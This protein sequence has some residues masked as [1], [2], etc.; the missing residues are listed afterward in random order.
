M[1]EVIS[2]A[3]K[4]HEGQVRKITKVPY[5]NHPMNVANILITLKENDDM[6]KAAYLHD[7]IED[8]NTTYEELKK[9]FGKIVA[10]LVR[11]LTSD[12]LK[13]KELGKAAYLA[14][15]MNTM[16]NDA[17]TVKLAD[18]LDNVIDLSEEDLRFSN[19][20]A[21]Q[22]H[23]IIKKI[24]RKLNDNQE[25]LIEMIKEKIKLFMK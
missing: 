5:I 8:T 22:T 7:T 20:Y 19:H 1:E 24:D 9:K 3:E 13:I 25:Y 23:K 14:N 16:S 15:K 11:E 10:K 21:K 17:F 6:I 12:S 2:F 4:K 18:R